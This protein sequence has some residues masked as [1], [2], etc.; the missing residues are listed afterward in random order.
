MKPTISNWSPKTSYM[1]IVRP[2]TSDS[3]G[4]CAQVLSATGTRL[5]VA[6][7][8][9]RKTGIASA[10]RDA[11]HVTPRH[12][13][14]VDSKNTAQNHNNTHVLECG[15]RRE[16]HRNLGPYIAPHVAAQTDLANQ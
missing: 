16:V 7:I 4:A 8:E 2:L 6:V 1:Y 10:A 9:S 3:R 14:K 15:F 12:V 5:Q 11:S 13:A